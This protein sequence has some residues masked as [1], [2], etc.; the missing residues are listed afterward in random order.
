[1]E[2][3]QKGACKFSFFIRIDSNTDTNNLALA[4]LQSGSRRLVLFK[5]FAKYSQLLL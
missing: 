5:T 4:Y 2:K 1:M 3:Y